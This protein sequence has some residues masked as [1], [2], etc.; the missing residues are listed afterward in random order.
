MA[1]KA[2][3]FKAKAERSGPKKTKAPAK[4]KKTVETVEAV[5]AAAPKAPKRAHAA[6]GEGHT[7]TRNASHHA[8]KKASFALEDSATKPSRKSTRASAN[9]SKNES[10][11]RRR[12]I[13]RAR[14]ADTRA[15]KANTPTEKKTSQKIPRKK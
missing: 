4:K 1:T 13:Q 7:A 11:L 9:H 3:K 14:S 5:E 12:Q 2:E 10:A 8:E 15:D 6:R